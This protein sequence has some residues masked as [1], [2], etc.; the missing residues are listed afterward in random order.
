MN[1]NPRNPDDKGT[2]RRGLERMAA[3]LDC[4]VV[5]AAK[6]LGDITEIQETIDSLPIISIGPSGLGGPFQADEAGI[7]LPES[8]T[9]P[10]RVLPP[11]ETP[12]PFGEAASR[13]RLAAA[14]R[15]CA[16]FDLWRTGDLEL[17]EVDRAYDEY[18]ALDR[19][20]LKD[21][22][23]AMQPHGK[24]DNGELGRFYREYPAGRTC[25]CCGHYEAD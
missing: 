12:P 9:K 17:A 4:T 24:S 19:C 11:G 7:A 13:A 20:P 5:D 8:A 6:V 21:C 1:I 23:G 22:G 3:D 2:T 10:D 16:A 18:R 14:E 25:D 15:V